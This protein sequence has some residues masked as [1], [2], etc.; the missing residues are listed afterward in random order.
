MAARV[1]KAAIQLRPLLIQKV[2]NQLN[3]LKKANAQ[4]KRTIASLKKD[5]NDENA[6]DNGDI[7]DAGNSFGDKA[8]KKKGE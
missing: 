7:E 3:Q 5:A 6:A 1:A 2:E 8:K 4:H